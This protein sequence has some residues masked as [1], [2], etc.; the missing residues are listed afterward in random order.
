[1]RTA[2]SLA[3][4]ILGLVATIGASILSRLDHHRSIRPSTLLAAYFSVFSLLG[5]A[6]LRTLCLIPGTVGPA[7]VFGLILGL[8]LLVLWLESLSKSAHLISPEKYAGSSSEPF[9]G[10]WKRVAYAWLLLTVR[11]GY[12]KILTVDELPDVGPQL[13]SDRLLSKL[14]RAWASGEPY[15]LFV[16]RATDRTLSALQSILTGQKLATS[17]GRTACC[18]LPFGPIVARSSLPSCPDFSFLASHMRSRS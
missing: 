17:Q 10:L 3:A 14:E 5:A 7:V 15:L 4:D 16:P 13:R 18:G 12:A 1:V 9:S 6:R 8:S 2:G 11:A